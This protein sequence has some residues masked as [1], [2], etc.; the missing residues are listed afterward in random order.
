MPPLAP[1]EHAAMP[2]M[3]APG[4]LA[5]LDAAAGRAFDESFAAVMSRRHEGAVAMAE[6]AM[7][8]AADPRVRLIARSIQH[9]QRNQLVVLRK[10]AASGRGAEEPLP[11]GET[12]AAHERHGSGR[13]LR[14][15]ETAP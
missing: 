3:P 13:V 15:R 14:G 1:A 10:L 7:G 4:E 5:R 2:G 6:E 9:A 8:R 12:P 11:P